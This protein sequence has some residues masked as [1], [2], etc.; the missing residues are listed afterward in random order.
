VELAKGKSTIEVTT[1]TDLIP[2]LELIKRA[3]EAGELDKEIE[4]A[5]IKLREGFTK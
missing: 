1:P 3:V 5:S 4:T 2:T